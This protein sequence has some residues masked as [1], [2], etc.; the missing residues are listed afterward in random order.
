MRS[1]SG[2]APPLADSS[3]TFR[4]CVALTLWNHQGHWAGD[5]YDTA[6]TSAGAQAHQETVNMIKCNLEDGSTNGGLESRYMTCCT[7]TECER[8]ETFVVLQ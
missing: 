7:L 5:I 3:C 4:P 6:A 1:H 8:K 2:S